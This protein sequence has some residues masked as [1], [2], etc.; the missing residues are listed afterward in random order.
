VLPSPTHSIFLNAD[1]SE[2]TV[3]S[4][5]ARIDEAGPQALVQTRRPINKFPEMVTHVVQKL[6]LACPVLGKRKLAATLA[7][8]GL[9]LGATTLGRMLKRFPAAPDLPTKPPAEPKPRVVTADY[10]NHVWH[11]D[12]TVA[13]IR[14]WWVPWL[15]WSLP[16]AWP[17]GWWIAAVVDHYSRRVMHLDC[18]PNQP[19]SAEV[20][21]FLA[22]TIRAVGTA[23]KYIVCDRG[24]QFDCP[25]FCRWCKRRKIKP[26]YGAVGK[27]GS[28]AVIERFIRTL[29][30]YLRTLPVVPDERNAFARELQWFQEWFNEHR[31][32][33][34]LNAKT[35]DEAY[36]SR[37][38]AHRKPRH[39]PRLRWPRGSPCAR[40][41]ALTRG[42][43]GANLELAVEFYRGRRGLPIVALKRVA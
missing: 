2:P 41:W 17:Y 32:H 21:A 8:A 1:L 7:R 9:H 35:P 11:V 24:G 13:P 18:F 40:P 20:Q 28:I 38:P 6:K 25:A 42:S 23:P 26:R 10:P 36:Y 31:P 14:G 33:E 37:F 34:F 15:P 29:K 5:L 12:L 4:W 22:K 3:A 27:H 19:T 30:E 39:E 16:Q 43:P